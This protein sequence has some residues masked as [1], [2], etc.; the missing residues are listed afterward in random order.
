[1]PSRRVTLLVVDDD[2]VDAEIIV[3]EV[4]QRNY[5]FDV[6]VAANGSAALEFLSEHRA[7]LEDAGLVVL[8]DL[9]MP[10]MNGHEF[11][12]QLRSNPTLR[13]CIVFVLT[14]SGLDR[15]RTLAYDKNVA[16]YFV[17]SN[18]EGLLEALGPYADNVEFPTL[19]PE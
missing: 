9:N 12:E 15:D 16:G 18:V 3:R 11:L 4:R 5:N 10:Y 14:T 17:K 7:Q 19:P 2:E 8:L 13:R 6:Q 1:M